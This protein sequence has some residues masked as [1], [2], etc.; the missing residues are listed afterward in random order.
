MNAT[1]RFHPR[2]TSLASSAPPSFKLHTSA[3]YTTMDLPKPSLS[4]TR[5]SSA[6][7]PLSQASSRQ[8]QRRERQ[9]NSEISLTQGQSQSQSRSGRSGRSEDRQISPHSKPA[10]DSPSYDGARSR[11]K[12]SKSRELRFPRPS[13][14]TSASA[15]GLLPTWSGSKDKER[16]DGLLRV[17]ESG[18]FGFDP[19]SRKGSLVENERLGPIQRE[20]Q[21]LGHLEK[22]KKRRKI[23]EEYVL[24]CCC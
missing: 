6:T 8:S 11:H 18:R 23:G 7:F 4:S 16:E 5:A 21:S 13:H 20:I 15:R 22:V 1:Y 2:P 12:H 24:L 14:L 9:S 3:S 19:D 10:L 17:R